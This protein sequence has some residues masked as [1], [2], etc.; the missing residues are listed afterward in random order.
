LKKKDKIDV[1]VLFLLKMEN[2][3]DGDFLIRFVLVFVF[4]LVL[5]ASKNILVK[6][7]IFLSSVED[8]L[9]S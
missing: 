1:Q 2:G 6:C 9:L 3:V 8:F 7:L 5:G 4:V